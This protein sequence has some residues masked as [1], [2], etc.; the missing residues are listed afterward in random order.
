MIQTDL[1]L[2]RHG[3]TAWSRAQRKT[4]STDLPLTPA[5]IAQSHDARRILEDLVGPSPQFSQ[6]FCSPTRRALETAREMLVKF[7]PSDVSDLLSEIDFGDYEGLTT[8]EICTIEPGW[9]IW[10]YGCRHGETIADV[11]SRVDQFV[12]TYLHTG[13]RVLVISH[14]YTLRV[15]AARILG[16]P[17][18][19]GRYFTLS[20]GS[21]SV[22]T[23]RRGRRA[24]LAW[25]L[26][27]AGRY[28]GIGS[29]DL[30]QF[31]E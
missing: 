17:P 21:V 28:C 4:G 31:R 10:L 27:G 6:V 29:G 5:G 7:D 15:L 22:V 18:G 19:Y 9:D 20:T 26:V 8:E 3:E 24:V 16:H 1:I 23:I 11:G 30:I 25:N 14:G 12:N 13:H 2:V